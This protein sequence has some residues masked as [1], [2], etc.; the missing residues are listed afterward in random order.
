MDNLTPLRAFRKS[1]ALTLD[2]LAPRLG[3]TAGQLS[4]IEREGTT[5]LEMAL[6]LAELTGGDPSDF[7]RARA[8]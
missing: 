4:R 1:Q 5:S 6:K 2:Q 7:S 8:A 3:V